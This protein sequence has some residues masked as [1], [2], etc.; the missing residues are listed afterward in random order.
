MWLDVKKDLSGQFLTP[1]VDP[2]GVVVC[3]AGL[4]R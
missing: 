1:P 3:R 2:S 4:T